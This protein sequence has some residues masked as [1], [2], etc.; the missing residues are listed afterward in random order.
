MTHHCRACHM[1]YINLLLIVIV[2]LFVLLLRVRV[3]VRVWP[4]AVKCCA[5]VLTS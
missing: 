1:R 2:L 3:R 4:H 5:A